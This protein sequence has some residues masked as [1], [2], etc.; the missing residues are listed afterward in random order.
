[1]PKMKVTLKPLRPVRVGQL[2]A[3]RVMGWIPHLDPRGPYTHIHWD[4]R[5]DN[6]VQAEA[7]RAAL[8]PRGYVPGQA[9]EWYEISQQH[10]IDNL[11]AWFKPCSESGA[12]QVLSRF[13]S[14]QA[15]KL[16]D[17]TRYRVQL[18]GPNAHL[19]VDIDGPDFALTVCRAAVEA[20]GYRDEWDRCRT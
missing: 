20:M 16:D 17:P 19:L 6:N 10:H 3:H 15:N 7:N 12:F 14:W 8:R 4:R 11:S 5:S 1:M 13:T 18:F 9:V 2:V